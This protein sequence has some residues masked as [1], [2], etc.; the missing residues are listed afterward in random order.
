MNWSSDDTSR[1]IFLS[2]DWP[3]WRTIPIWLPSSSRISNSMFS[4][5]I[6]V[7]WWN[8]HRSRSNRFGTLAPLAPHP[9]GRLLVGTI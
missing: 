6:L 3:S 8:T 7:F 1:A 9:F 2:C 5:M 4:S